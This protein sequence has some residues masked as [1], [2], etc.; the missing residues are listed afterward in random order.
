MTIEIRL[1]TVEDARH[2]A[3]V[4]VESFLDAYE[5]FPITHRSASAALEARVGEWSRLLSE[6][7][8]LDLTLVAVVDGEVRGFVRFGAS[9]DDHR[10]GHIFS[11]HVSPET[12]GMGV[13][14][15][16]IEAGVGRL[17]KVG[18]R[19]ANLWV[20]ADNSAARRFYEKLGWR[21]EQVTR[22]EELAVGG[23][24]GDVVDVVRYELD[25]EE[26]G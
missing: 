21:D 25:L 17:R 6:Q 20:V 15:R 16:L 10:F 9:P 1:A 5:R 7:D 13:G 14:R 22:R 18:F 24:E 3:W 2:I 12:T 19:A 4:H 26:E 11:I 23:E 8:Q